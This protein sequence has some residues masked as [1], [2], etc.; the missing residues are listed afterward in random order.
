MEFIL[1]KIE[2]TLQSK[3]FHCQGT[4]FLKVLKILMLTLHHFNASFPQEHIKKLFC[5]VLQQLLT[6]SL[7]CNLLCFLSFSILKYIIVITR[8]ILPS[9]TVE[10]DPLLQLFLFQLQRDMQQEAKRNI[11]TLFKLVDIKHKHK[12]ITTIFNF[13]LNQSEE[14]KDLNNIQLQNCENFSSR[15]IETLHCLIEDNKHSSKDQSLI[16]ECVWSMWKRECVWL[17]KIWIFLNS[18]ENFIRSLRAIQFGTK[19]TKKNV[20]CIVQ[21]LKI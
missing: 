1:R 7:Y 16:F 8:L 3:D 11:C 13:I 20:C 12:I 4:T 17:Q 2:T 9:T 18:E 21:S 6:K 5:S 10:F 19:W 15:L 14:R